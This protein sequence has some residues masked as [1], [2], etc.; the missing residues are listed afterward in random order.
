MAERD[1][2]IFTDRKERSEDPLENEH[3]TLIPAFIRLSLSNF[4]YRLIGKILAAL[5]KNT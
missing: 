4:F 3:D 1:S 5:V 2:R